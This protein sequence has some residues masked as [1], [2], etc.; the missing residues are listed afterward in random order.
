MG[1]NS[2]GSQG[3]R[4]SFPVALSSQSYR[5]SWLCCRGAAL[6]HTCGCISPALALL[7]NENAS[8]RTRGGHN[9]FNDSVIKMRTTRY[10]ELLI[11]VKL[12]WIQENCGERLQNEGCALQMQ[13]LLGNEVLHNC[14]ILPHVLQAK[15]WKI[16]GKNRLPIKQNQIKKPYQ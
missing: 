12:Q 7:A 3:R 6:L 16:Q 1:A 2:R 9:V 15:I 11:D 13:E 5:S 10:F 8:W 4:T 14:S